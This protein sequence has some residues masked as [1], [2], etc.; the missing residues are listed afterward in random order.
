MGKHS[1][2]RS[3]FEILQFEDAQIFLVEDYPCERSEQLT[4]RERHYIENNPC[5]NI[6]MKNRTETHRKIGVK[7]SKVLKNFPANPPT[8]ENSITEKVKGEEAN[9]TEKIK[10]PCGG[11]YAPHNLT[12]HGKTIKHKAY[13]DKFTKHLEKASNI[14][15][16]T[17]ESQDSDEAD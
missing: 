16:N 17:D 7:L 12:S 5:V 3:S 11:I 1:N 8:I 4:A 2:H 6:A 9:Q 14:G 15:T 13:E 10:C